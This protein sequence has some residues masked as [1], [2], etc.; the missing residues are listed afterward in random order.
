VHYR[1][2]NGKRYPMWEDAGIDIKPILGHIDQ[3]FVHN[4]S[5]ANIDPHFGSEI[6]YIMD[7]TGVWGTEVRRD[8]Y[9]VLPTEAFLVKAHAEL[10]ELAKAP[11]NSAES[12]RWSA[13]Q[14]TIQTTGFPY[15]GW[16][17]DWKF[18]NAQNMGT[19]SVPL[20]TTCATTSCPLSF[21]T[22]SYM[23]I[24]D[25]QPDP[26]N[27]YKVYGRFAKDYAW[28]NKIAKVVWRGALSENDPTKVFESQRWRLTTKV[29]AMTDPKEKEMFDVG[30]TNIPIFLTAQI[31]IDASLAGGIVSGIGLMNDF[32]KYKAVLDMDGNSWS[33]RFGTMLC[34]NSVALKVE[35][36][37]ADFWFY[38]L[39]P[40][41]H[42]IPIKNDLSDLVENV[43]FALDPLNEPVIKEI[44][45]SANQWCSE[46]FIHKSLAHDM[47]DIWE[48]YIQMLDR[49]DPN[50]TAAWS[51]KKD[52]LFAP[53]SHVKLVELK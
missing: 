13:L 51:K 10:M 42:Y 29:T 33:S 20:F 40:W 43:Q 32:Q 34:Y 38:D 47:L 3:L 7:S 18:C 39:V 11:A 14:R 23:N 6:M 12:H 16:Y 27:W 49:A 22:P 30:F 48:S 19:E 26:G 53:S 37:Y 21:P 24:I 46:R 28:E 1:H 50:W 31:D 9:R 36:A 2:P 5:L 15:W 41:K 52:E 17:G 35:P 45:D 4:K 25:S 44:I 8:K